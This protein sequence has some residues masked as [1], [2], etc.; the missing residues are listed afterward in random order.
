MQ[1]FFLTWCLMHADF[2]FF[3]NIAMADLGHQG[4]LESDKHEQT[5]KEIYDGLVSLLS[6]SP[7]SAQLIWVGWGL[8]VGF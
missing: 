6:A 7:L 8:T 1:E 3:F 4:R 2:F 5:F